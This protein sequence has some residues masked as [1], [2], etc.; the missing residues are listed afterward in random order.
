MKNIFKTSLVLFM[1][2][3][4]I[5]SSCKKE[6]VEPT[7]PVVVTPVTPTVTEPFFVKVDG[8]E[9]IEDNIVGSVS[10]WSQTLSVEASRNGG[11]EFVRLK[12]T[13]SIAAGTYNFGDPDAGVMAA[14]YDDGNSIY[15]APSG[16]GSLTIVSNTPASIGTPGEIIGTFS[17]SA[18][19]YAFSTG[20]DSYTL[21]EGEFIVS[22]Q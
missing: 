13:A 8:V 17:F 20:S 16:T 12:M 7:P 2:V 4:L 10:S 14:Y 19:A 15:G 22:Y 21:S 18:S 1:L 3:S 5:F 11:A 6:E 9:F